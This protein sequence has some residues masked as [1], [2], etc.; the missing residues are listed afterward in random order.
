MG[1]YRRVVVVVA[2]DQ[3][4]GEATV[5][6]PSGLGEGLPYLF[7]GRDVS[8]PSP[9]SLGERKRNGLTLAGQFPGRFVLSAGR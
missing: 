1:D 4:L 7:W 3:V 9:P 2:D 5:E 6:T 8:P